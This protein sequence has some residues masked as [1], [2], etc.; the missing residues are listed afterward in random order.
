MANELFPNMLCDDVRL[1][2]FVE[3]QAQKMPGAKIWFC[4]GDILIT[5]I[6]V[7]DQAMGGINMIDLASGFLASLN[8]REEYENRFRRVYEAGGHSIELLYQ[9]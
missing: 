7:W 8:D 9:L 3:W 4:D 2:E 5:K 1:E 6:P